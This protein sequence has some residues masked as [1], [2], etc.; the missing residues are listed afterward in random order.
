MKTKYV[1]PERFASISRGKDIKHYPNEWIK[2]IG[3]ICYHI[4]NPDM[5][6]HVEEVSKND[7]PWYLGMTYD[8]Y[9][10]QI[11]ERFGEADA[12]IFALRCD[13]FPTDLVA[14]VRNGRYNNMTS[15]SKKTGWIKTFCNVELFRAERLPEAIA[16]LNKNGFGFSLEPGNAICE[17]S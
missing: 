13:W 10:K 17:K 15:L 5:K 12:R 2:E 6:Y 1:T 4:I 16:I 8:N 9:S 3:G 14:G 11:Q 7:Y